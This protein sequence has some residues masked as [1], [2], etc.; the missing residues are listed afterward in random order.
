MFVYRQGDIGAH[1]YSTYTKREHVTTDGDDVA[2]SAEGTLYD[3]P[4]EP[5]SPGVESTPI[6]KDPVY[7]LTFKGLSH[8]T[9]VSTLL[10]CNQILILVPYPRL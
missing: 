8:V 5:T 4:H 10:P 6:S 7:K 1:A 2:D 9:G 3:M